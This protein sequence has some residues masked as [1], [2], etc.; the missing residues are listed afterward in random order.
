MGQHENYVSSEECK[1]YHALKKKL[2]AKGSFRSFTKRA[3]DALADDRV[4]YEVDDDE[5]DEED[6]GD[7]DALNESAGSGPASVP[8]YNTAKFFNTSKTAQD[9]RL[10]NR[11]EHLLVTGSDPR[12]CQLCCERC[13]QGHPIDPDAKYYRHGRK[14]TKKCLACDVYLC[15]KSRNGQTRSCFDIFHSFKKLPNM[16]KPPRPVVLER[17]RQSSSRKRKPPS[18]VGREIKRRRRTPPKIQTQSARTPG[19]VTRSAR[20]QLSVERRS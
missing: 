20:R 5:D 3:F 19:A 6:A 1:S 14:A 15:Q 16:C 18:N 7:P 12:R 2:S 11:S 17:Q 13:D 9:S 10:Q 8:R 4:S